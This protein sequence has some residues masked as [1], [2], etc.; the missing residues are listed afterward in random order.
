MRHLL[1][2]AVAARSVQL[3][4]QVL[5]MVLRRTWPVRLSRT[6]WPRMVKRIW[7]PSLPLPCPCR[8]G[9]DVEG[10]GTSSPLMIRKLPGGVLAV[11]A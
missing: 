1:D 11:G 8:V 2:G 9:K 4:R 6:K 10:W 7:E 3:T 5:M